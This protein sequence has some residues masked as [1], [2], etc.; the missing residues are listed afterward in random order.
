M[1]RKISN[2][3]DNINK[4]V[5]EVLLNDIASIFIIDNLKIDILFCYY[6]EKLKTKKYKKEL[7]F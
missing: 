7:S 2:F 1:K 5:I 4:I 6:K 3:N